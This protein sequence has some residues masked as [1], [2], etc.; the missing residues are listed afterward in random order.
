MRLIC[1]LLRLDGKPAAKDLLDRM[2]AQLGG[3]RRAPT[4][5]TK[6][7]GPVGLAV[8]DYSHAPP[9]SLPERSDR[10]LAA[11]VRL[12]EPRDLARSVG[13]TASDPDETVLLAALEAHGPDG[14]DRVLGDFA[15]ASWDRRRHRLVCARD[16]FGVR[17]F[18]YL[19]RPG[20]LFAF[21]SFP[22]ALH[23]AG[24]AA[25][26]IDEMALARQVNR[27]LRADDTLVAGIK[28]LPAA[29]YLSLTREGLVLARYFELD[30]ASM[31]K[32]QCSP[33]EAAAEL[34]R[35]VEQAV[36]SRLPKRGETVAHLSGGL[37]S[38]AVAVLAG[39]MLRERGRRLHAFSF[40]DR[41][42]N[43][44]HLEDESEF[45]RS[46]LDQEDDI[47]WAPIRAPV[48][49]SILNGP[50]D[51]DKMVGLGPEMYDSALATEAATLG[52]DLVLSGWGGDECA[53]FNGRGGLADLFLRGRW[54]RLAREI[55][56][57]RREQ[58]LSRWQALRT[59]V[60]RPLLPSA[61]ARGMSQLRGRNP[62]FRALL[63]ATLSEP[64]RRRLGAMAAVA[65][66][67][68]SG[69]EEDR[70]AAIT[71]PHIA[72]RA[73]VWAVTGARHGIGYAFP[74]L[75]RRVVEY[76][77]SLPG[78]LFLRGGV[79][80]RLFRDAMS[81]VLPERVRQRRTKFQVAP[82][83]GVDLAASTD[84]MLAAIDRLER[85]G[86]VRRMID[87]DHLRREIARFPRAEDVYECLSQGRL[88]PD[89]A[90]IIAVVHALRAA[91]YIDQHVNEKAGFRLGG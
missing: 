46:V 6:V 75:D 5:R 17:P 76:A 86:A 16:V 78:D 8:A 30:R 13:A 4:V 1:G 89:Q 60:L 40:L 20:E 84:D 51:V 66:G 25:R 87:L 80:R 82:S 81:G 72:E 73:E 47:R 54:L 49:L 71:S 62:P 90:R 14:L 22:K 57:L 53:S 3:P 69:I 2:V 12:D 67:F 55:S 65:P 23:G 88:H 29:H 64:V 18:A 33:T 19:H 59:R 34:R 77:L 26:T 50:L 58:G 31:G 45:V 61:L 15:F 74:L 7:D 63:N 79:G 39:R 91:A 85:N 37:D 83:I 9:V 48:R 21:A 56:A 42:R 24:L 38:S 36:A 27:D 10:V 32:R 43:D 70:W 11:D 44:I 41:Q 52:A 28:R 35:L 68:G